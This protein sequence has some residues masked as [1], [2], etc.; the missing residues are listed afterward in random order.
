ML[1]PHVII[2][3][4]TPRAGGWR[5]GPHAAPTLQPYA[6]TLQPYAPTL[7]PYAPTLQPY[8]PRRAANA[9]PSATVRLRAAEPHSVARG[10]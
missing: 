8:A 10:R 7:Q 4:A 9:R 2:R 6:P 3:A 5:L 1:Q